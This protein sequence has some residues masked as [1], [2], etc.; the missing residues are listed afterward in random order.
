MEE[1]HE[2]LLIASIEISCWKEQL[3]QAV[4]QYLTL[5]IFHAIQSIF[6]LIILTNQICDNFIT[7]LHFSRDLLRLFWLLSKLAPSCS[8][9]IKE[10]WVLNPPLPPITRE[11]IL[12]GDLTDLLEESDYDLTNMVNVKFYTYSITFLLIHSGS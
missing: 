6:F 12:N 7:M 2:C 5:S 1:V 8:R 11:Q 3:K 10:E 9:L 4:S